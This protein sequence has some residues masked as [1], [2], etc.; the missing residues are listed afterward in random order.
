ME[1]ARV[2]SSPTLLPMVFL[3]PVARAPRVHNFLYSRR[4]GPERGRD[5][6]KAPSELL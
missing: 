5:P 4:C 3:S 1:M 2:T 6:V